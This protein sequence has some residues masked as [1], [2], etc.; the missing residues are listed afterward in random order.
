MGYYK[1]ISLLLIISFNNGFSQL[2]TQINQ[3][4]DFLINYKYHHLEK[5]EATTNVDDTLG[6]YMAWQ[7]NAFRENKFNPDILSNY[8][9]ELNQKISYYYKFL[10][11]LNKGEYILKRSTSSDSLAIKYFKE[12]LILAEEHNNNILAC[13]ALK[14]IKKYLFKFYKLNDDLDFYNNI[15]KSYSYDTFEDYKVNFYALGSKMQKYYSGDLLQKPK[16]SDYSSLN[17]YANRSSSNYNRA[18]AYQLLGAYYWNFDV[19]ID[20]S[21]YYYDLAESIYLTKNYYQYQEKI[22]EINI[23]RAKL[24]H[25]L[26]R[27]GETIDLLEKNLR[28]TNN[29][30]KRSAYILLYDVYFKTKQ[31]KKSTEILLEKEQFLDNLKTNE[32]QIQISEY[33]I[34]YQTEKKEKENLQLKTDVERQQR[35]TRN[36]WIGSIAILLF[37]G[38]TAFLLFK[39]TKRKQK[40]A[41]QGKA[42]ETQKL[43][44]VLKEQEL[45]SIDAMIEGQEKERQRIANDLHDDLGGLMATVKLHFN[46]L[47]DKNS[48]E[49]FE[50]TNQLI[51]EAYQKVRSVAHAKNSGVIAKQ[52]LL[53]AVRN[54]ANNISESNAIKIDVVDHGLENR[55][56]NSLELTIFRIIQELIT[57]TIKHASATECTIHLTN[58]EDALNIMVEDNG[59]G[60]NPKQ[61]TTKNKGM[62]I[63]S[64]DKRVEHLNGSMTI[65]SENQKGTTIIIDIPL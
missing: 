51:D 63:S 38:I 9:P 7:L 52:G 23:N 61:I 56:E 3:V 41:E 40:L 54:M 57:N 31:F 53:K 8:N 4:E 22:S 6:Y 24:L 47:K 26:D 34:Q 15:H 36:L 59:I 55:L 49:L 44:T 33:K 39:N 28:T 37:V 30:I 46:A 29:Q 10:H 18:E 5:I 48:P 60:F 58:H 32:N 65:E 27:Y 1:T 21:F 12:A 42:L 43:A 19:K 62:G 45:T 16:F 11:Y 50:K 2:D 35:R 17:N 14:K 20:S 13:E 25:E 64:I